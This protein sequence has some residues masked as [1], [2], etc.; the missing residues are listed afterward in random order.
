MDGF[1]RA[2]CALLVVFVIGFIVMMFAFMAAS[3][4]RDCG[5]LL[6][7]TAGHCVPNAVTG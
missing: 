2:V 4:V 3:D 6:H 5:E 1:E 7:Y